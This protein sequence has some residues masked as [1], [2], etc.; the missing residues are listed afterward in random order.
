[1]STLNRGDLA[2]LIANETGDTI[3]AASQ[4]LSAFENV[5]KFALQSGKAV[6]LRGFLKLEPAERAARTGH[7]PATGAVIQIPAKRVVKAK[8]SPAVLGEPDGGGL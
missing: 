6:D 1:M 5:T 8:V 2:R 7:N 4:F 3:T